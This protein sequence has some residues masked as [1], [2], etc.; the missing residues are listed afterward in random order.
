MLAYFYFD[1]NDAKKQSVQNCLSSLLAQLCNQADEIPKDLLALYERCGKGYN[2]PK[3]N[4]LISSISLF[5]TMKKVEDIFLVVDA[6][7]ECP[8]FGDDSP[9]AEL[10]KVLKA[11]NGFDSSNIH[12]LVTS[13]QEVDIREGLMP[14]LSV[15]ALSI[16]GAATASDIQIY[17]RSQLSLEPK[18]KCWSED[19]KLEIE[20]ALA[21]SADGM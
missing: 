19:I 5:A 21:K 20:I 7:D 3:V 13:R 4:E 17:I 18:F 12:L 10:L 6:L 2:T 16:Q 9:R 11:I 14:L 15:P 8:K 1:F